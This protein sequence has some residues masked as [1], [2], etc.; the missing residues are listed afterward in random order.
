MEALFREREPVFY[1]ASVERD[2]WLDDNTLL[3]R[4]RVRHAVEEG[5]LAQSTI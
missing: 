3:V 2:E 1:R 4:G 5:G